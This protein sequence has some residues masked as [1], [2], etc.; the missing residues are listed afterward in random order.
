MVLKTRIQF[1]IFNYNF[2][3]NFFKVKALTTCLILC[4]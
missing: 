3:S 2:N 1:R 4:L